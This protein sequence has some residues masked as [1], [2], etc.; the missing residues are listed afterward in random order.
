MKNKRLGVLP[1]HEI[2]PVFKNIELV[3]S[4]METAKTS[5]VWMC[6]LFFLLTDSFDRIYSCSPF[7]SCAIK[8]L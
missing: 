5:D 1:E 6:D 7:Y 2:S 3:I 4:K 8:G